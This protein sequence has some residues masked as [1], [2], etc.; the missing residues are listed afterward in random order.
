M[1]LDL[2]NELT[3]R[4]SGLDDVYLAPDIPHQMRTTVAATHAHHLPSEESILALYDSTLFGLGANGFILTARRICWKNTLGAPQQ[5]TYAEINPDSLSVERA[6]L[7][8]SGG[9]IQSMMTEGLPEVLCALLSLLAR[10][11]P[12]AADG[13][14]EQLHRLALLHLGKDESVFYAPGIP[15]KKLHRVRKIHSSQLAVSEPVLVLFDDTVFGG[16]QDGFI[17]TP[18]RLCWKN[19]VA[20]PQSVRWAELDPVTVTTTKSQVFIAGEP[21]SLTCET[22]LVPRAA[23]AFREIAELIQ[24]GAIRPASASAAPAR[25]QRCTYCG[26]RLPDEAVHCPGCGGPA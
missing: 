8:I 1:P 11:P 23:Q 10:R 15:P 4:L 22:E 2:Q 6:Q 26:L 21:I 25:L 13:L 17:I 19:I 9:Q 24:H 3:D 20:R 18:Q 12:P 7:N 5:I 14:N 16:A